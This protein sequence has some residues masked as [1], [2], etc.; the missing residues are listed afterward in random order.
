[1]RKFCIIG[2]ITFPW[3]IT[4][5]EGGAGGNTRHLETMCFSTCL[6]K[7]IFS[8]YKWHS[9]AHMISNGSRDRESSRIRTMEDHS[10]AVLTMGQDCGQGPVSA[11]LSCSGL[12]PRWS[13]TIICQG[14]GFPWQSWSEKQRLS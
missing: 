2:C 4:S 5:K 8:F 3:C 14:S 11:P 12:A 10:W 6:P 13:I 9:D 1:M 7:P